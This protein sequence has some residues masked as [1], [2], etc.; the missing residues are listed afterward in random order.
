MELLEKEP[1]PECCQE[2]QEP[3]CWECDNA[4]ERWQ[5]ALIDQLK[6]ERALHYRAMVRHAEKVVELDRQ[7]AELGVIVND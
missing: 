7:L 4:G 2:C 5:M 1:L 6:A 3:D